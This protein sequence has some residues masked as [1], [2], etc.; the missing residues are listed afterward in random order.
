MFTQKCRLRRMTGHAEAARLTQTIM[1]GGSSDSEVADVAVRP[2]LSSP[3]PAVMTLTP[4]AIWRIASRSD[5]V[6][7]RGEEAANSVGAATFMFIRRASTKTG[8][9]GG[10]RSDCRVETW[11][12]I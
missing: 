7:A 3:I 10:R 5:G 11:S 9:G 6:A 4:P 12:I 2:V 1:V 8:S